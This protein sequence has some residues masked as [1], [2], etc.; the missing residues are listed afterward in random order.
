MG[1]WVAV[2]LEALAAVVLEEQAAVDRL[3]K[4]L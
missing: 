1:L 2:D 3:R 4:I